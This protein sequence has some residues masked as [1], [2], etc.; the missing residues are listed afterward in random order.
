MRIYEMALGGCIVLGLGACAVPRQVNMSAQTAPAGDFTVGYESGF[1]ASSLVLDEVDVDAVDDLVAIVTSDTVAVGQ[2]MLR[3]AER[4]V[5]AQGLDPMGGSSVISLAYGLGRHWE[6]SYQY[7]GSGHGLGLRYGSGADRQGNWTYALGLMG[8]TQDYGLPSWLGDVQEALGYELKRMD[9]TLPLVIGSHTQK[10]PWWAE[11]NGVLQGQWSRVTYAFEP[12]TAYKL[13]STQEGANQVLE[14]V[15]ESEQSYW[16]LGASLNG[17]L[18]WKFL[19]LGLGAGWYVQDYGD[20]ALL[21]G[22]KVSMEGSSFVA[23]MGLEW[24]G[25]D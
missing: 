3:K 13:A 24:R 2:E 22:E 17:R 12:T 6:V 18:G 8:S 25:W 20:Y 16:S 15:P 7:L 14:G 4:T 5:L 1:Q 19:G 9:V 21:G 10:G 11:W 23:R